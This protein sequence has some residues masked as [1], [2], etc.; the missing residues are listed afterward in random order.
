MAHHCPG[1][2]TCTCGFQGVKETVWGAG[3]SLQRGRR[4]E[5]GETQPACTVVGLCPECALST[6]REIVWVPHTQGWPDA[7]AAAIRTLRAQQERGDGLQ[8]EGI[9]LWEWA[10][11]SAGRAGSATF[12]TSFGTSRLKRKNLHPRKP[13]E[14]PEM[15]NPHALPLE[16]QL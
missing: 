2:K 14:E 9:W 15:K 16:G 12:C 1:E 4:P 11:S 8:V 5:T 10:G 6:P 13:R 3:S 7:A